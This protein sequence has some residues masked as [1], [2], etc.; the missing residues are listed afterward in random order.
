[1]EGHHLMHVIVLIFPNHQRHHTLSPWNDRIYEQRSCIPTQYITHF[2]QSWAASQALFRLCI[3]VR[4]RWSD[5]T[6]TA[7]MDR[8]SHPSFPGFSTATLETTCS[9]L[10]QWKGCQIYQN[11]ISY[12]F[13]SKP[14]N[15]SQQ[16]TK[17]LYLATDWHFWIKSSG[18][19]IDQ[20]VKPL[21]HT[22]L[23]LW[24]IP[25]KALLI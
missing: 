12:D 11:L 17:W 4:L 16:Q 8:C 1:M 25:E 18:I 7:E 22:L 14:K 23:S 3:I 20:L 24:G 15:M 6:Q 21:N 19:I 2:L 13:R 9:N 10:N 5:H